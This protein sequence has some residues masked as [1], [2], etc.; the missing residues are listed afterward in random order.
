MEMTNRGKEWQDFA[1]EVFEHV[2]NYTVPQYGDK[3]DDQLEEW[4]VE[5]CIKQVQKYLNRY[6][7]NVRP[8]QQDMDFKKAAHYLQV[9]ASKHKERESQGV[10]A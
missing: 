10:K 6:D 8:G 1:G 7:K 4:T 3:P 5:D 9:A 2:N